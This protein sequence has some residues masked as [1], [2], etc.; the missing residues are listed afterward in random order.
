MGIEDKLKRM[1]GLE[2]RE[3]NENNIK[4]DRE[5]VC[6]KVEIN[7]CYQIKK[8]KQTNRKGKF[9]FIKLDHMRIDFIVW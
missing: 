7:W 2:G 4:I 5:K 3:S 9:L 8:N 1:S 6:I